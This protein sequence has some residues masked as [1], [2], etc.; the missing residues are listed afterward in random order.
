MFRQDNFFWQDRPLRAS[1]PVSDFS[2]HPCP[3][4]AD[5]ARNIK[6][7]SYACVM[8]AFNIRVTCHTRAII[9]EGIGYISRSG[10]SLI[11][12]LLLKLCLIQPSAGNILQADPRNTPALGEVFSSLV[13]AACLNE[14]KRVCMKNIVIAGRHLHDLRV[15][16]NITSSNLSK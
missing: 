10:A 2:G 8:I 5:I 1:L 15:N 12:W 16:N 6:K 14:R 3:E 7:I 11:W 4:I 9:N 13:T